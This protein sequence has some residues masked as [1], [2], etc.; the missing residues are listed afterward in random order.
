MSIYKT[1]GFYSYSLACDNCGEELDEQFDS[2]NDAVEAKKANG[3]KSKKVKGEW[4]DWCDK[5]CKGVTP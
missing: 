1:D 3:W 5:C 4:E 2:F